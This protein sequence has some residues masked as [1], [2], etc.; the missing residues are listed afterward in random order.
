M[1]RPTETSKTTGTQATG[2]TAPHAAVLAADVTVAID[3]HTVLD[4]VDFRAEAGAVHALIGPNGAGK[5]TLLAAL[6]GDVRP[7]T[8]RIEIAGRPVG[9]TRLRD[10]A[11]LRAVLPQEHGVFFPFTVGEVIRMGRNP[12]ARTPAEDDDDRVVAWAADTADVSHL[13]HRSVPTLS[14]GE[15]GRSAFARVL[16][17]ATGVLLLDEPTAALDIRHQE[18]LLETARERADSGDA[19]VIVLHDLGAAAAYAD[20]VTLLDRGR[21]VATGSVDHVM[22]AERLTEVYQHPIDVLPGPIVLPRRAPKGTP[23]GIAS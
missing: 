14:G 19:V 15:R 11:R 22:T 4:A 9:G 13:M 6:S 20:A 17:Q 1:T 2:T 16:A 21:V 18:A 8:G 3:G 10:L 7:T 12:W 23:R 5:S